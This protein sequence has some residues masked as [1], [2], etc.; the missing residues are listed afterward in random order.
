MTRIFNLIKSLRF[1]PYLIVFLIVKKELKDV[2]IYE[3]DKWLTLNRF[4]KQGIRGFMSLL[5]AF[6]EY[7]SLFIF[8]TE[9]NWLRYFAKGQV[10]LY[11]HM[12]PADIGKGLMIWHGYST[13]LNAKKIGEDF[14]IWQNVT[15][16]KKTTTDIDDRPAIG[17]NV[18]V[19]TGAVVIGEITIGN[20]AIIG[21]NAT[22]IKNIPASATAVG[23]AATTK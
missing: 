10:N 1:L 5:V 8:R 22:V 11:F 6:P 13:V 19:C 12:R 2:L 16:G 15:I 9:Q 4:P 18:L 21:A 7:R 14:Q 23:V 20:N 3:R 17:D